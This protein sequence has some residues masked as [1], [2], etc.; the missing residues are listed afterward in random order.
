MGKFMLN[1]KI[2]SSFETLKNNEEKKWRIENLD[3]AQYS[4]ESDGDCG[5]TAFGITRNDA[6]ELIVY[7]ISLVRDLI[8]IAVCEALLLDG[9]LKYLKE[10]SFID[11][12]LTREQ[13]ETNDNELL[14]K[15]GRAHV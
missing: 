11:N 12:A 10:N 7:N 14:R 15:I 8:K 5:Y 13:L 6:Y 1:S 3:F 4:V 9:F 2:A